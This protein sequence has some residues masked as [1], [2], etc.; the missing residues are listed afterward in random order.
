MPSIVTRLAEHLRTARRPGDFY[1]RGTTELL[2]PSLSVDGVGPIAMPLLPV[3]A[4][5][6]VAAAERAPYGRGP[7]TIVDTSVRNSWQIGPDR[8]RIGGRHWPKT[9]VAIL[10]AVAEGL[11]VADPIEAEFYKL[12]IYDEGSFFVSHRDTEKSPGMFATLVIALPSNCS[13]GELVVRHKDRTV[14]LDLR[15]DDPAEAP[16]AAFYADCLHEV[17]PVTAGCRLTLVYNLIRRGKGRAPQPPSYVNEQD[18]VARLLRDWRDRMGESDDAGEPVPEKLV[19]PMEH[20][21]T[22]PELGFS[23]LKGADAAAAGMLIAA[24]AQAACS[25]HLALVTLEEFGS[26]EYSENYGRRRRW[27]DDDRDGGGQFEIDEVNDWTIALSDWCAPDGESVSWGQIPVSENE[28]SPPDP[29]HDLKPDELHFEEAS[30]NA[31]VSFERRYRRAALVVWPSDRT[32]AVLTRAGLDVTIPHLFDLATRWTATG[33]GHGS[34]VWQQAHE[35]AGHMIDQWPEHGGGDGSDTSDSDTTRMLTALTRLGDTEQ[36]S[37]FVTRVVGAGT[38]Y[39]KRDNQAVIAAL[40]LFPPDQAVTSLRMIVTANAAERFAAC[41]NLLALTAATTSS[42]RPELREPAATLIALMPL[43]STRGV[44]HDWSRRRDKF[45]AS[46]VAD[47]LSALVMIDPE[48]AD[49]AVT[50]ILGNAKAYDLDAIVVPAVRDRLRAPGAA[51][52]PAVERLRA[53]SLAHLRGRIALPLAPPDDWRRVSAVGCQCPRCSELSRFLADKTQQT[54]TLR[55]A[56]SERTHVEG[57]IQTAKCDVDAVTEQRGRPYSLICTK[58]QASYER[59]VTE[60]KRDLADE[61]SLVDSPPARGA[62]P[63]VS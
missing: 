3:Q 4:E 63:P 36:I 6:L 39:G 25:L 43:N 10:D 38:G 32:L 53:A 49:Q 16:F 40:G 61:A 11:G 5:Q 44:S 17:L 54:W 55:A 57:T 48:L 62:V 28:L 46:F 12:L 1:V 7:D 19:Y 13:G 45:E 50:Q 56:A 18:Q 22:A 14:R 20:A 51:R 30:G 60:R 33:E 9:L 42:I 29:F 52:P 26:A 21:Y 2:P 27:S 47:L 24:T 35:L 23:V 58:N 15:G 34:L 59:R 31:G 8:V 37:R 41:A